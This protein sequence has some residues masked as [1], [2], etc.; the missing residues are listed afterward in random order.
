MNKSISDHTAYEIFTQKLYQSLKGSSPFNETKV[1][2]NKTLVGK[3]GVGYQIDVHWRMVID[4][5]E[6]L[7]CI[8]CKHWNKKV[9]ITHISAFH[10]TLR[11]LNAEGIYITKKGYQK[12]AIQ[13][14]KHYSIEILTGEFNQ[15]VGSAI[16]RLE[17]PKL[18]SIKVSYELDSESNEILHKDSQD[19]PRPEYIPIFNADGVQNGVL[20][21]ILSSYC[22]FDEGNYID[23]PEDIYFK[24]SL[25]HNLKKIEEISYHYT[26]NAKETLTLHGTYNFVEAITRQI[27]GVIKERRQ[28]NIDD[29]KLNPIS[30][31]FPPASSVEQPSDVNLQKDNWVPTYRFTMNK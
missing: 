22:H 10:A 1:H 17:N 16:M 29:M 6:Y 2:H 11:D 20:Q 21:D 9:E 25:N 3:S 8:E 15:R 5:K 18:E 31:A 7:F 26:P 14:A 23:N 30:T 12:G 19:D 13:L 27:D 4:G 24:N 28:L